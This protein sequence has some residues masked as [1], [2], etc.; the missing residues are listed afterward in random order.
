MA[1][2]TKAEAER[3][4]AALIDAAVTVFLQRGVARATLEEVARAAG[5]TRG[6]VY[7]HFADK[8][9]LFLAMEERARLPLEDLVARI[10]ALEGDDPLEGLAAAVVESFASL[11][12]DP[13]RRR[14]LTVLLLRCEYTEDMA[15]AADRQRQAETGL[16]AALARAFQRAAVAGGLAAPWTA[17]LAAMAARSMTFGLVQSWLFS[18][19][20]L[21]LV[22]QGGAAVRA[23]LGTMRAGAPSP[24]P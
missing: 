11:E 16:Q 10:D 17:D 9:A 21:P 15:P 19:G 4:R 6:A 13:E 24:R 20:T 1:R 12:S 8:M 23:L 14:V 7:W 3:T 5:V 18:G 2:K 22:D